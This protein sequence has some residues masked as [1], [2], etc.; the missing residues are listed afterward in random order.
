MTDSFELTQEKYKEVLS[1]YLNYH[2]DS[3][4]DEEEFLLILKNLL[5]EDIDFEE[6]IAILTFL[7]SGIKLKILLR[8]PEN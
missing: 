5:K 3:K 4:G 6:K 8:I 7:V 1:K 2:F